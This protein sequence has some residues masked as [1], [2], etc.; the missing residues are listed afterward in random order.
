MF[1]IFVLS[2]MKILFQKRSAQ[3]TF[4]GS[5]I[6]IFYFFWLE[7]ISPIQRF[8]IIFLLSALIEFLKAMK[9]C[10]D[11]KKL[12]DETDADYLN[13]LVAKIAWKVNDSLNEAYKETNIIA[14]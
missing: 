3:T 10:L 2:S 13:V 1:L 5:T 9:F 6:W 4:A 7:R 8:I 12:A 14:E 11:A